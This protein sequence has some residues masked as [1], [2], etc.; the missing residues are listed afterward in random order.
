MIGGHKISH[1]QIEAVRL[2][3]GLIQESICPLCKSKM[4]GKKAP[5]L[6]H[7]HKTGFIRGVLCLTCNGAEGRIMKRAGIAAGKGNDP[8][9]WLQR[10]A[11][12]LDS[13][14]TPHWSAQGRTG[15]IH[16]LHK[17]EN[18]KRLDRLAKAKKVRAKAK[19]AK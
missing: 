3:I 6:D 8:V 15:L 5:C 7:D 1:S 19:A 17:T 14:R 13:H 4:R 9:E 16:P 18:E 12:Y 2:K 11:D 10:M